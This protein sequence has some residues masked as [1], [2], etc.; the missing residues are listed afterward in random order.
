MELTRQQLERIDSPSRLQ[1]NPQRHSF[2]EFFR[3]LEDI[4]VRVEDPLRRVRIT[5]KTLRDPL[6]RISSLDDVSTRSQSIDRHTGN[7][8]GRRRS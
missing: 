8:L 5:Q 7:P 4:T 1:R 2:A 3:I 6:E